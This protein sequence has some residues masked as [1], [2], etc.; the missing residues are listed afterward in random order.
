V[1]LDASR[2]L[3]DFEPE[4]DLSAQDAS[5]RVFVI[6]A[7]EELVVARETHRLISSMNN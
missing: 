6:P 1:R 5:V 4:T 7:N 2:N 3:E